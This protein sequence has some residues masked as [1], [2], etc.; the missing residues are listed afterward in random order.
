MQTDSAS[1]NQYR[2]NKTEGNKPFVHAILPTS[3]NHALKK[4][5]DNLLNKERGLYK[6]K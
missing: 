5:K 6:S 3:P 1:S 2:V 4:R